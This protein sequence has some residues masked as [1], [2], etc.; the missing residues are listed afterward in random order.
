[1]S[2]SLGTKRC[3]DADSTEPP[4]PASSVVIMNSGSSFF[5]ASPA[6]GSPLSEAAFLLKLAE[7]ADKEALDAGGWAGGSGR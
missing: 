4:T 2:A 5:P 6:S 3:R 7:D 1:M